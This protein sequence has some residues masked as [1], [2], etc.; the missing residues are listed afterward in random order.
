MR[1]SV[2]EAAKVALGEIDVWGDVE[3]DMDSVAKDKRG[4]VEVDMDC[5]MK[6]GRGVFVPDIETHLT[7]GRKKR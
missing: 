6:V 4:D 1:D 5:V 3:V 2:C 7:E